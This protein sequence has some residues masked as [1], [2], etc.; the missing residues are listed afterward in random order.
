MLTLSLFWVAEPEPAGGGVIGEPMT[1]GPDTL[2]PAPVADPG[3]TI[4]LPAMGPIPT[5]VVGELFGT[6]VVVAPAPAGMVIP[7]GNP[8]PQNPPT[9]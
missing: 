6:P 7:G 2:I 1:Q 4:T 5:N 8:F 9:A 3:Q